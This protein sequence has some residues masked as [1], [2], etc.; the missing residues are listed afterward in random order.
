MA[1]RAHADWLGELGVM[2]KVP[3]LIGNE[4]WF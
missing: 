4:P 1:G 3:I 2:L